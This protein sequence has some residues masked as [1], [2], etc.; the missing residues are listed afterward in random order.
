MI[1]LARR[2][3]HRSQSTACPASRVFL[4]LLLFR[5]NMSEAQYDRALAPSAPIRARCHLSLPLKY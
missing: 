4:D 5:V 1:A 3:S 2:A